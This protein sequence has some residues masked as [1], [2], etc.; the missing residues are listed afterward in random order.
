VARPAALGPL[1]D[2]EPDK[3]SASL[4]E[5]RT[6]ADIQAAVEGVPVGNRIEFMGEHYRIADKVGLMPLMRFAYAARKGTDA[7]DMEGLAA[8]YDMLRDCLDPADWIRFQDDA[9]AKKAD[10]DQLVAVVSQTIEVLTARPTEPPSDSS[11]GRSSTS[12]RSTGS[13]SSLD[14]PTGTDL[15]RAG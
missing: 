14:T 10:G 12:T 8:I 9:T 6:A 3:P 15:W 4:G 1:P 7:D 13:S 5:V 11:P 2:P